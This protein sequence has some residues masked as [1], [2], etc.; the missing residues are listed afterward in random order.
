MRIYLWLNNIP[1]DKLWGSPSVRFVFMYWLAGPK[2]IDNQEP[3]RKKIWSLDEALDDEYHCSLLSFLLIQ[4]SSSK[5][6]W[7]HLQLWEGHRTEKGLYMADYIGM[8]WSIWSFWTRLETSLPTRMVPTVTVRSMQTLKS[9]SINRMIS[10]F[11]NHY[12][13]RSWGGSQPWPEW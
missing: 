2:S 12:Y 5:K 6:P 3:V 10:A 9:V 1:N 7:S 13:S 11:K 4:T 8:T